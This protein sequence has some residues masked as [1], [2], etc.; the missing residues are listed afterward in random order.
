MSEIFNIATG[1][2]S[3]VVLFNNCVQAFEY[4]QLGRHFGQDF[5]RYQLKLDVAKTRL[6]R[7]GEAVGINRD[8]RFTST[9]TT[10]DAV[11]DALGILGDIGHCFRAAQDKSI[12][13]AGR[14]DKQDLT[15]CDT[16]DMNP[17]FQRLHNRFKEIARRR[18]K[19][20]DIIKKTAWAL[21]DG[22]SFENI[23]NQILSWIDELEKLFP[24]QTTTFQ[25]LAETEIEEVNDEPS[26]KTLKDA[27]DG[28]DPALEQ[29]LE[30]K[31]ASIEVNNSVRNVTMEDGARFHVGNVFS[32][33]VLQR[34]MLIKD[35]TNNSIEQVSAKNDARI[36]VGNVYGGP[37]F[38]NPDPQI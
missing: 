7:W 27:A 35:R 9:S 19:S 36:R 34:K 37:G 20:T 30:R 28:V 16:S 11:K 13:Y 26:L 1:A 24:I 2:L 32:E 33:T 10:D 23:V 38:Y 29:A 15:V 5:E 21:Y 12:R 6:G 25:R 22:K 8:E 18:Q 14:A 31:V 17:I 4:I 3:V